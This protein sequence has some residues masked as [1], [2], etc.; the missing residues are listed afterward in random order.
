MAAFLAVVFGGIGAHKF[1]LNQPGS[2]IL[3]LLFCWTFIPAVV[4]FFEGI[5][6]AMTSDETFHR[7][8]G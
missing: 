2:G 3:Y 6:Y 7:R 1:Y 4:G 8:F 5:G